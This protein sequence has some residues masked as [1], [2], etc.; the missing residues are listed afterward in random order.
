MDDQLWKGC[1]EDLYFRNLHQKIAY[2]YISRVDTNGSDYVL[3]YYVYI[4][5]YVYMCVYIYTLYTYVCFKKNVFPVTHHPI[6]HP[7]RIVRRTPK[8]GLI[9]TSFKTDEIIPVSHEKKP[10]GYLP[11]KYW[12]FNRDPY[13]GL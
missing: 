4:Y 10:A 8:G 7:A 12:L 6:D 13:N 5:I 9:T 11:L 3:V 2:A 1:L